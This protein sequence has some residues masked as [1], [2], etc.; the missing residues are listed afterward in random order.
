MIP[1]EPTSYAQAGPCQPGLRAVVA[2]G[3]GIRVRD[4]AANVLDPRAFT[5]ISQIAHNHSLRPRR[6]VS[7][8][9]RQE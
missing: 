9:Q 2:A 3:A 4:K 7:I 1:T 5:S 8:G 6:P